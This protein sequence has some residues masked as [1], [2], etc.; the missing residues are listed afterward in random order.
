[1]DKHRPD[2]LQIQKYLN[3]ELDAK[4][5]HRLER[6]AQHDPL[7]M[8]ALEGYQTAT[9]N[10]QANLDI[11]AKQLNNRVEK[12]ERRIIPWTVIS[13]AAGVVGFMIVVGPLYKSTDT[14]N[15][16]Q[17]AQVKEPLKSNT[18]TVAI[19]IITG[20][21]Q[22]DVAALQPRKTRTVPPV[23]A[24]KRRP[25]VLNSDVE[26]V[27]SEP[28]AVAEIASSPAVGVASDSAPL[29]EMVIGAMMK[30]KDSAEM[31]LTVAI[32]KKSASQPLISKAEGVQIIKDKRTDAN[33]YELNKLGLPPGYLAGTANTA[34]NIIL[35]DKAATTVAKPTGTVIDSKGKF[36]APAV[37][38]TTAADDAI[39]GLETPKLNTSIGNI[40]NSATL[41]T[42]T[43]SYKAPANTVG[44]NSNTASVYGNLNSTVNT[45]DLSLAHPQKGW[46]LYQLYLAQKG[47][48]PAGE[49]PG[50]VELKV[51]ISPTGALSNITVIKSLSPAT[52][53]KAISLVAQGPKWVGNANGKPEEKTLVLEFV[54]KK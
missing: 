11:L 54:I 14:V 26:L 21:T 6:E 41:N 25:A 24:D 38:P 47:Y 31:P 45:A 13:I 16:P 34:N 18:D 7:L 10:Q 32:A 52:D 46:I 33:Q 3:G 50:V 4:A 39:A 1:M 22:N 8:D 27:Q 44:L 35:P 5:M 23:V 17:T 42:N 43:A 2:I 37:N 28:P 49:K 51:T 20:P 40:T 29:D 53:K 30:K 15:P 9:N 36:A 19:P 48:L 12:K